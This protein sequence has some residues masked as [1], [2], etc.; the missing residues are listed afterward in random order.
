MP[1]P[2]N[3]KG[4]KQEPLNVAP[5][6][7]G[8]FCNVWQDGHLFWFFWCE[9]I[10]LELSEYFL[11]GCSHKSS[12][13]MRLNRD[14]KRWCL[15]NVPFLSGTV[16]GSEIRRLP[17]EVGSFSSYLQGF[18]HPRWLARFFSS[19]VCSGC[20]LFI[21]WIQTTSPSRLPFHQKGMV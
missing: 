17:V 12:K 19:T 20:W 10:R 9:E 13:V 16:D 5:A 2:K 1:T 14:P 21:V 6:P 11:G 15:A 8:M 7:M 4:I 18:I 3:S